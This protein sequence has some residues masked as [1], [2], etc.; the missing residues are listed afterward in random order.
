MRRASTYGPHKIKQANAY[1]DSFIDPKGR[2]NN[3]IPNISGLALA[4]GITRST[5]YEWL[6]H[7]D[8]PEYKKVIDRMNCVQEDLTLKYGLTGIFNASIAKMVLG[9]HGYSDK[10][11]IDLSSSDGSMSPT[12][13][14]NFINAN[15]IDDG[16]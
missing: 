3:V 12:I 6:K 11:E 2:P 1:L 10:A 14:V 16:E 13:N 9:K 8:K 4:I 7:D 15:H 5:A